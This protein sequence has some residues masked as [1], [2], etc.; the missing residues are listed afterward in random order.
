M[1]TI[2][3]AARRTTKNTRKVYRSSITGRFIKK[4]TALKHRKTSEHE[5]YHFRHKKP[6]R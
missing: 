3:M 4:Q 1:N 5:T 2:Q 6:G